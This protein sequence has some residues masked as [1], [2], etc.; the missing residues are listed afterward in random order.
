MD[1]H[2]AL[3]RAHFDDRRFRRRVALELLTDADTDAPAETGP[4]LRRSLGGVRYNTL[5][6]EL[7]G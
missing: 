4:D 3:R 6:R 7:I 1:G 5:I 2:D